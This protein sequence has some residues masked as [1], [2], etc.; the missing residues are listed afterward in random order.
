MANNHRGTGPVPNRAPSIR[1]QMERLPDRP[2]LVDSGSQRVGMVRQSPIS[3]RITFSREGATVQD[4]EGRILDPKESIAVAATVVQDA[5]KDMASPQ[6]DWRGPPVSEDEIETNV[7]DDGM[8]RYRLPTEE[9]DV[10]LERRL[11]EMNETGA[12]R[13]IG[14]TRL[15][16]PPEEYPRS[17]G[18]NPTVGGLKTTPRG[19]YG[20]GTVKKRKKRKYMGGGRVKK[21]AKGGGIRK[22]KY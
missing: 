12:A 8:D 21:Y 9:D 5:Q 14:P 17:R 11:Q 1:M 15:G 4:D 2:A 7:F 13:E 16:M 10:A 3:Y 18:L 20:G 22:A 6:E 19:L